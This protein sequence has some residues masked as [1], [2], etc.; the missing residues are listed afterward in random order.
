LASF[1]LLVVTDLGA[2]FAAAAGLRA[3]TFFFAGLL[4]AIV[5]QRFCIESRQL[6]Q[7]GR[8][9]EADKRAGQDG[10]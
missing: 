5:R 10:L 3:T 7:G 1:L 9:L 2:A 6:L 8:L 4:A